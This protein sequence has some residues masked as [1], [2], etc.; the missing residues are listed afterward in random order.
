MGLNGIY[1][2]MVFEYLGDNFLMFIKV[3]NYRGLLLYMVKQFVREIL[4]G[5][6]YLYW[7]FFIIYIDLKFENVLLFFLLD[8]IKD[9]CNFDYVLLVFLSFGEKLQIF[10]C[11]DKVFFLSFFKNQKKKVKRNVKKVSGNGNDRERENVD[12]DLCVLKLEKE[13]LYNFV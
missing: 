1:V 5:F 9:F 8:F 4:I 13:E 10:F 6:D 2:C 7:Q 11:V 12:M 3:Y